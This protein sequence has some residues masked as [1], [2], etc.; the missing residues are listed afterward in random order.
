MT[1]VT[2]PVPDNNINLQD[3]SPGTT[4]PGTQQQQQLTAEE[5]TSTSVAIF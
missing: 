1:I 3:F 5:Y 2:P 4:H